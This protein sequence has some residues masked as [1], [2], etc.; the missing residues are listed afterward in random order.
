LSIQH[1]RLL[2][3]IFTD[4]LFRQRECLILRVAGRHRPASEPHLEWHQRPTPRFPRPS[5]ASCS[6]SSATCGL[7]RSARCMKSGRVPSRSPF[8][9]ISSLL[10]RFRVCRV[11]IASFRG[12]S[13]LLRDARVK[14]GL[15]V[16]EVAEQVGVSQSSIYFWENDHCRPR[17]ANLSTLC[18]VLKLPARATIQLAAS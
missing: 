11:P 9:V 15:S 8:Q 17:R 4:N 7:A 5:D 2:V 3:G 14:R 12:F 16:A 18:K 13:R 1:F 6:I 10:C